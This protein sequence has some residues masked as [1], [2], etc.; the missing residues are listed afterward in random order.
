MENQVA[1]PK[2]TKALAPILLQRSQIS[3]V[4]SRHCRKQFSKL[5]TISTATVINSVGIS[6]EDVP[7]KQSQLIGSNL[8]PQLVNRLTRCFEACLWGVLQPW[9]RSSWGHL[10]HFCP[11][12][13]A[14]VGNPC[15]QAW[16]KRISSGL[17]KDLTRM[18]KGH[19][20]PVSEQAWTPQTQPLTGLSG[21][22]KLCA[23]DRA[24]QMQSLNVTNKDLCCTSTTAG[25][26]CRHCHRNAF[27]SYT[28]SIANF[29]QPSKSTKP[30]ACP[31]SWVEVFMKDNYVHH[32]QLSSW[33]ICFLYTKCFRALRALF[34]PV[35]TEHGSH[36]QTVVLTSGTAVFWEA[37][38]KI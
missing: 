7:H 9:A 25:H 8:L 30:H 13:C 36:V 34:S 22:G 38:W 6:D 20:Q 1:A 35:K 33:K 15:P 3:L 17:C 29:Q 16:A 27:G 21:H 12:L 4:R 31:L 26:L 32:F 10:R 19:C 28:K 37:G 24:P 18:C 2:S 14:P 23:G 11:L 5:Q